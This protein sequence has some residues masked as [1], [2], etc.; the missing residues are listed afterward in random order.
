M[1]DSDLHIYKHT[2]HTLQVSNGEGMNIL[3]LID[4]GS[5]F[6]GFTAHWKRTYAQK[7]N[8]TMQLP[9]DGLN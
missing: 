3:I 2:L 7:S 8:H 4:V 1:N 5:F 6:L 9:F